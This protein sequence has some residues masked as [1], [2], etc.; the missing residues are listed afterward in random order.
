MT[1]VNLPNFT[2][3]D[4][5]FLKC[6][7]LLLTGRHLFDTIKLILVGSNTVVAVCLSFEDSHR[8]LNRVV[9]AVGKS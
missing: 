2:L 5:S 8:N 4:E 3:L 6:V 9:R 1:R 7:V